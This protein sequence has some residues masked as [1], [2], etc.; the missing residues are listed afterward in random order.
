MLKHLLPVARVFLELDK[1]SKM[2]PHQLSVEETSFRYRDNSIRELKRQQLFG[3]DLVWLA[4]SDTLEIH[5][6]RQETQI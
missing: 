1:S 6:E 4:G 2:T 5:M 3:Q